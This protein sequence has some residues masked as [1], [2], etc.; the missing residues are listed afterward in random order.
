[1][2]FK[3]LVRDGSPRLKSTRAARCARRLKHTAQAAS[4]TKTQC[5]NQL[6]AAAGRNLE[7]HHG[8]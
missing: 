3:L 4:N 1:M 7:L 5:R 2:S 6:S 8:P